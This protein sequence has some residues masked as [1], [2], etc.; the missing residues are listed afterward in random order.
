MFHAPALTPDLKRVLA[1]IRDACVGRRPGHCQH[2]Q[3]Y[4]E[5]QC[6]QCP[7]RSPAG[8]TATLTAAA[9]LIV[10]CHL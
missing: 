2:R 10:C 5:S 4:R 8:L 7:R 1:V 9:P 3:P 6:W